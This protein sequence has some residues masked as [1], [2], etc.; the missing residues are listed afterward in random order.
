M[1]PASTATFPSG[2]LEFL[3]VGAR[4]GRLRQEAKESVENNKLSKGETRQ[5][6]LGKRKDQVR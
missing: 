2:C 1:S 5:E 3:P 6:E 4:T